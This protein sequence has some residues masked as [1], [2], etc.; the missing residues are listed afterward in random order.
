MQLRRAGY[1]AGLFASVLLMGP[2]LVANRDYLLSPYFLFYLPVLG[3]AVTGGGLCVW[4]LIRTYVSVSPEEKE[5][6]TTQDRRSLL[7]WAIL[8]ASIYVILLAVYLV[9]YVLD[10]MR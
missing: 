2:L 10:R 9:S 3:L 4:R 1:I 8:L 7:A 5:R 6:T